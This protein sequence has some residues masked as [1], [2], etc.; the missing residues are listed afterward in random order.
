MGGEYKLL[1][2]NNVAGWNYVDRTPLWG[3]GMVLWSIY[4]TLWGTGM[5]LWSI[6]GT[7][8]IQYRIFHI[9]VDL[10]FIWNIPCK[11]SLKCL[12]NIPYNVNLK[13]MWNIPYKVS[14]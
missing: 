10:K 6:Y 14:L 9:K 12:W 3:T 11:R 5:V 1:P 8:I 2:K 4:G 13:F 7:L